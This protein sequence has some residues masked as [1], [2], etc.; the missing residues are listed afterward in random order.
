MLTM[1]YKRKIGNEI[2]YVFVYIKMYKV[3]LRRRFSVITI[4][5]WLYSQLSS[6]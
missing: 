3:G 4:G 1:W 2:E 6:V 5:C